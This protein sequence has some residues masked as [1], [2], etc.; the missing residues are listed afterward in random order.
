MAQPEVSPV[1]EIGRPVT[2]RLADAK[3]GVVARSASG[4]MLL[5]RFFGA[6]PLDDAAATV[7]I[8]IGDAP[9][10]ERGVDP[11]RDSQLIVRADG[12]LR[13]AHHDLG[14]SATL[15]DARLS[16]Q[17]DPLQPTPWRVGRHLLSW[18]LQLLHNRAGTP[19]IHGAVVARPGGAVVITG[20][21]G[22]GKSTL[23]VAA[24]AA[25]WAVH[26]DD[27]AIVRRGD[28]GLDVTTLP[29][30]MMIAAELVDALP[31]FDVRPIPGDAR[32]RSFVLDGISPCGWLPLRAVVHV[33]HHDDAGAVSPATTDVAELAMAI[34]D[35]HDPAILRQNLGVAAAVVALPTFELLH[36]RAA[37]DRVHRAG[38]LLDQ[39]ASEIGL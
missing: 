12:S 10:P 21:S 3:A 28:G 20:A 30:R 32:R 35:D 11:V 7:T 19:M 24:L 2:V 23:A 31:G 33:S 8:E 36:A 6:L 18:G 26:G 9:E 37:T 17:L 27:M 1:F 22:A 13:R 16:V 4:V 29:R 34:G 38:I 5:D 14:G 15:D 39:I 25:G